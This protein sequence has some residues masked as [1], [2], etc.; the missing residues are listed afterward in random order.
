MR[1]AISTDGQYVSQHFG[2]CPIYTLVDIEDGKVVKREEAK[3]PG[4]SAGYI[5]EFLHEKG[6]AQIVCGG[7]GAR[8][9]GFFQEYN[10]GIIAGVDGGIDE[11][12]EKLEKGILVGGESLCTPGA[13]RGYGVEKTEC[14]HE[15]D[16]E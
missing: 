12:I 7:I 10:I 13:G 11:T 1:I 16:S 3:N 2:R 15:S 14:D 5:P 8:A 9:Q 6:V 4:H